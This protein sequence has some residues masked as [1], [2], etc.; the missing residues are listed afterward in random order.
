MSVQQS[1]AELCR[2]ERD[3]DDAEEHEE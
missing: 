2:E 3:A 1:A